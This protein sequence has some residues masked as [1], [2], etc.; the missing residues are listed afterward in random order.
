MS[1]FGVTGEDVC[2][3]AASGPAGTLAW[4]ALLSWTRTSL[5]A[6]RLA[7]RGWEPGNSRGRSALHKAYKEH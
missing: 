2:W 6:S 5:E 7:G 1:P 4:A 3:V